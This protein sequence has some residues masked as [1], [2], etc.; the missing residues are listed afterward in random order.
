MTYFRHDSYKCWC[1]VV[2]LLLISGNVQ[3]NPGPD[4]TTFVKTLLLT[5]Q[6]T[7]YFSLNIPDNSMPISSVMFQVHLSVLDSQVHEALK[8]FSFV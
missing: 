3:P 4:F 5:L 7:Y 1:L 6:H 8:C 2:L